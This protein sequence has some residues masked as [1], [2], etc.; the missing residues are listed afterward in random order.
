MPSS[1]STQR[2]AQRALHRLRNTTTEHWTKRYA[3]GR[4]TYGEPEVLHWGEQATLKVGAFCSF[5]KGV[6]IFLGGNHR[7]D[8]VTTF[9]F[10]ALWESAKHIP[11]HPATRGDVVIGNDVWI[12][13]GATVLSGVHVGD[14][15]VVGARAVVTTDVPPYSIVAGNPARLVRTRF[16][17]DEIAT[18]QRIAW[19]TWD[20][21]KI[22]EAMPLLLDGDISRFAEF[23]DQ[24]GW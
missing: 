16:S 21:Q 6:T 17:A 7:I 24:N 18:L 22:T 10:P 12:G 5:A 11:G 15:A 3:V 23:V 2:L 4:W 13:D 1:R 19:W 9:P 20:D 8:W 14:G